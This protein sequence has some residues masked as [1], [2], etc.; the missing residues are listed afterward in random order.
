M[1][2]TNPE[3]PVDTDLSEVENERDVFTFLRAAIESDPSAPLDDRLLG[4]SGI[5]INLGQKDKAIKIIDEVI[6]RGAFFSRY[7]NKQG[8]AIAG[9]LLGDAGDIRRAREM[10]SIYAAD[11]VRSNDTYNK[12]T[13]IRVSRDFSKYGLKDEARKV[14]LKAKEWQTTL[15]SVEVRRQYA[16]I[17]DLMIELNCIDDAKAL[18]IQYEQLVAD[19]ARPEQDREWYGSVLI[20]G[21]INLARWTKILQPQSQKALE[22]AN[23]AVNSISNLDPEFG[24]DQPFPVAE[25]MAN[26]AEAGFEDKIAPF[27]QLLDGKD[28]LKRGYMFV[29]CEYV[30]QGKKDLVEQYYQKAQ[31]VQVTTKDLNEDTWTNQIRVLTFLKK[32]EDIDALFEE[33]DTMVVNYPKNV[34][35]PWNVILEFVS[36]LAKVGLGKQ[37]EN[38]LQTRILHGS[39][40][41]A[42]EVERVADAIGKQISPEFLISLLSSVKPTERLQI[43][44]GHY[45]FV[46]KYNF[47]RFAPFLS[48]VPESLDPD[49]LQKYLILSV[50]PKAWKKVVDSVRAQTPSDNQA[51]L[52]DSIRFCLLE[53]G[54]SNRIDAVFSVLPYLKEKLSF[55]RMDGYRTLTS[56]QNVIDVLGVVKRRNAVIALAKAGVITETKHLLYLD[57]DAMDRLSEILKTYESEGK[58]TSLALEFMSRI[59]KQRTVSTSSVILCTARLKLDLTERKTQEDILEALDSLGGITP[60]LFDQFR[61]MPPEK[62]Q[63]FI[64]GV[65]KLRD[66]FYRNTQLDPSILGLQQADFD[67]LLAEYITLLYKPVGFSADTVEDYIQNITRS[68]YQRDMT[69]ELTDVVK[70]GGEHWDQEKGCYIVDIDVRDETYVWKEGKSLDEKTRII[71]N[72]VGEEIPELITA[73][74]ETL[75]K[76]RTNSIV[77]LIKQGKTIQPHDARSKVSLNEEKMSVLASLLSLLPEESLSSLYSLHAAIA[78]DSP[79]LIRQSLQSVREIVGARGD[80]GYNPGVILPARWR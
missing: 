36:V 80:Q 1:H 65:K 32:Q 70:M 33:F 76:I 56:N 73:D 71:S 42:R 31:A 22:Y 46:D 11:L 63:L 23:E 48:G 30:K 21:Y 45:K 61:R 6:N 3:Q 20:D 43:L 62:K 60:I 15:H 67:K 57:S 66:T 55:D 77:T 27:A 9:R 59:L 41:N 14:L 50:E 18:L 40:L 12:E 8:Y 29:A 19:Y 39:N 74:K 53:Y 7:E 24:K 2:E 69:K 79:T 38:Y 72:M 13:Y 17:M 10:L 64:Q 68:T 34:G 47:Q 25:M 52:A 44:L 4:L 75:D 78:T 5:L 26:M 54:N 58:S 37:A 28:N 35:S 16:S 51:Q 49:T